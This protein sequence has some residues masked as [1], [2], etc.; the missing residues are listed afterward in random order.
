MT[1]NFDVAAGEQA[2]CTVMEEAAAIWKYYNFD[3]DSVEELIDYLRIAIE[4]EK[5]REYNKENEAHPC[6]PF[7]RHY[8]SRTLLRTRNYIPRDEE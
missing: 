7:T 5:I 6:R 2:A 1:I 4:G 3:P 8:S